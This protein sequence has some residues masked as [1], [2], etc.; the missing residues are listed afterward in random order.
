M[1]QDAERYAAEDQARREAAEELNDA[2][3]LCY[4]AERT[5]ADH[6]DKLADDLRARIEAA[7]C[8]TKAAV[9]DRDADRASQH[10][11]ALKTV[12]REVGSTLYAQGAGTP[13][14]AAPGPTSGDEQAGRERAGGGGYL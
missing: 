8:D 4:Q 5:L 14:T 12:L 10:A 6:G 1:I 2:D 11:E 3:A 9:N 13:A 7:L